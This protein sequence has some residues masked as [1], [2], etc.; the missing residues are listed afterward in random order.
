MKTSWALAVA[1]AIAVAGVE[2]ICDLVEQAKDRAAIVD[3]QTI[4]SRATE[5]V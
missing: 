4:A 1:V 5:L 3:L 2:L